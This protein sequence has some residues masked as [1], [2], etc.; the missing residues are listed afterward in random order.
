MINNPAIIDIVSSLKF[1][2]CQNDKIS[3]SANVPLEVLDNNPKRIYS[4]VVNNSKLKITLVLGSK[5]AAKIDEGIILNPG[6]SFEITQANLYQG[7]ISAISSSN[8]V[9]SFVECEE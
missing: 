8:A 7:K 4:A 5:T 6:G 3:L 2:K 1:D 9:V